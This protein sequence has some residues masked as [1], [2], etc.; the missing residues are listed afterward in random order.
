MLGVRLLIGASLGRISG[1]GNDQG[2]SDDDDRR[3]SAGMFNEASASGYRKNPK[4]T[5]F[6]LLANVD[7]IERAGGY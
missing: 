5:K 3:P 1:R 2:S 4:K 6:W 7:P